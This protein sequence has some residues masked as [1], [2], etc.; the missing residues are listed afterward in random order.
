LKPST[1]PYLTHYKSSLLLQKIQQ[2]FSSNSLFLVPLTTY[3]PGP[4]CSRGLNY[5]WETFLFGSMSKSFA[6]NCLSN[7][8]ASLFWFLYLYISFLY[9]LIISFSDITFNVFFYG[10]YFFII[11]DFLET[12]GLLTDLDFWTER[13]GADLIILFDL[14]ILFCL[15]KAGAFFTGF[16]FGA[17]LDCLFYSFLTFVG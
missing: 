14:P 16:L 4:L 5:I 11:F 8:A 10:A 1:S 17:D 12:R 7:L 6:F 13:E 15:F 9:S 2:S 3:W